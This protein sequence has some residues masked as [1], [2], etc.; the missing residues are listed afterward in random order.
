MC[1]IATVLIQ[2]LAAK[3]QYMLMTRYRKLRLSDTQRLKANQA[4]FRDD[5]TASPPYIASQVFPKYRC[6]H[7]SLTTSL[8]DCCFFDVSVV[9][10]CCQPS[11]TVT[12][13]YDIRVY[14]T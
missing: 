12:S 9:D 13:C 8:G 10:A 1:D 6:F 7:S 2:L 11:G 3:T 14:S 4:G 5:T